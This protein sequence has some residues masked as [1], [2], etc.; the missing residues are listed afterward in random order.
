MAPACSH[1]GQRASIWEFYLKTV[2]AQTYKRGPKTQFQLLLPI[3]SEGQFLSD[4]NLQIS[5]KLC[6]PELH[7]PSKY[8]GYSEA[9][10]IS[11]Q[12]DCAQCHPFMPPWRMGKKRRQESRVSTDKGESSVLGHQGTR[13]PWGSAAQVCKQSA[14]SK[15]PSCLE[16]QQPR[17]PQVPVTSFALVIQHHSS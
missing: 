15:F 13:E 10:S 6:E 3:S 2:L 8:L 17:H 11:F 9:I 16:Y 5:L 12:P 1:R 7:E 14:N 4:F